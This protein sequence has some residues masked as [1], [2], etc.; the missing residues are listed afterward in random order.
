[1]PPPTCRSTLA[2]RRAAIWFAGTIQ[3]LT[4]I[5]LGS[6]RHNSRPLSQWGRFAMHA[7]ANQD[8]D[9]SRHLRLGSRKVR[10]QRQ[11][12][13]SPSASPPP[14]GVMRTPAITNGANGPEGLSPTQ[15]AA[16]ALVPQICNG[17]PNLGRP[18]WLSDELASSRRVP[19]RGSRAL[20]SDRRQPTGA[21]SGQESQGGLLRLPGS[22]PVPALGP[23]NRGRPWSLGG[24]QRRGAPLHEAPHGPPRGRP[25]RA[26]GPASSAARASRLTDDVVARS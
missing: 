18:P 16:V 10:S 26:V 25:P 11:L 4:E 3:P 14:R 6:G 21:R 15:A 19:Q 22:R 1:M 20:L 13:P 12:P 17:G 9:P 24:L 23:R 7:S 2:H 8:D 5:A